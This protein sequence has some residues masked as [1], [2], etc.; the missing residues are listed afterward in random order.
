MLVLIVEDE[1]TAARAI[2]LLL[3]YKGCD[4]IVAGT[5]A[6]AMKAL[7]AE[8]KPQWV[9]LDLMLPDGCGDQVLMRIKDEKLPIKVAVVSGCGDDAKIESVKALG[10]DVYI[11]KP[12]D[13]TQLL[14]SMGCE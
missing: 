12:V 13:L 6:A 9:V 2:S 8:K 3:K 14:E 4:S 5:V 1:P 11:P 7:D 10:P